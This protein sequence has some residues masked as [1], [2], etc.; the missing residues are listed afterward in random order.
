MDGWP[1]YQAIREGHGVEAGVQDLLISDGYGKTDLFVTNVVREVYFDHPSSS[2]SIPSHGNFRYS[3]TPWRFSDLSAL[4]VLAQRG[5]PPL[6][7]SWDTS[8][9]DPG[10]KDRRRPAVFLNKVTIKALS[11]CSDY[12]L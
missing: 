9:T 8:A 12:C 4:V 1:G 2:A 7:P 6:V 5:P 3:G 10:S 11:L